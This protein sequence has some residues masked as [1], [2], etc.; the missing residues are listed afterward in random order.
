[1]AKNQQNSHQSKIPAMITYIVA[2]LALLCGLLLPLDTKV[3]TGGGIDFKNMPVLQLTGAIKALLANFGVTFKLPFGAELSDSYSRVISFFGLF[4]LNLGAILLILYAFVTLIAVILLI[5]VCAMKIKSARPRKIAMSAESLALAV[6]LLMVLLELSKYSGEWNLSVYI[7][8]GI[9]LLMLILQSLIYFKGSG[10]IKTVG[11]I[12]S[13]VAVLI[14]IFNVYLIIPQLA[15]PAESIIKSMQSKK[16]FETVGSL[17]SLNRNIYHGGSLIQLLFTDYKLFL[18]FVTGEQIRLVVHIIV[19]VLAFTILLDLFLTM[20]GIGK[21]TKKSMLIA[22]LLRYLFEIILIGAIFGSVFGLGG[23]YGLCLYV[24]T[25]IVLIQLIITIA[26]LA[27]FKRVRAKNKDKKANKTETAKAPQTKAPSS[28]T[29]VTASEE[30]AAAAAPATTATYVAPAKKTEVIQKNI[31]Y[32]VNTV[33]NG[34]TD[35]FIRKLSNEEKVEFAKVFLERKSGNLANIPQYVVGGD[36]TIFF[37]SI[38]IYL[39]RVRS[40]VSDNLMNKLY[41]EVHLL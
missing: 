34:P 26:R 12:L 36:N 35:N 5:F 24:L 25:C 10:F 11:F 20:F 27:H 6:L 4:E 15:S 23:N 2:V 7:P 22:N 16:P 8:F 29:S 13:A 40:L 33:Y 17:F 30:T 32:N 31:V 1:M 39:S 38:F 28:A 9:I 37:K 14:G 18:E 3:F 19:M 21:R 41:E